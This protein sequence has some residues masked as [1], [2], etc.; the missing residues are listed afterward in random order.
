M[1]NIQDELLP[2]LRR[3]S[4]YQECYWR[5]SALE[6]DYLAVR[7]AL[8]VDQREILDA[9]IAACEAQEDIRLYCAY[10]LGRKHG[11]KSCVR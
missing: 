5:I 1:M 7:E 8:T 2:Q 4:E 9:Y 10:E 3:D 6:P 11:T